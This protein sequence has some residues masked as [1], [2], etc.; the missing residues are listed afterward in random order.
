MAESKGTLPPA[1]LQ[2]VSSCSIPF[3]RF[4]NTRL[5]VRTL[6]ERSNSTSE[7]EHQFN[8]AKTWHR[9]AANLEGTRILLN[10]INGF[11]VKVPQAEAGIATWA[12]RRDL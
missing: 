6:A 2:G 7:R 9:I 10:A 1:S 5:L 3:K 12:M 4:V 8:L 11:E